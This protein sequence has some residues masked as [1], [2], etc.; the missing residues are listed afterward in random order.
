MSIVMSSTREWLLW[1]V[2]GKAA[3]MVVPVMGAASVVAGL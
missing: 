3:L 1:R 2:K